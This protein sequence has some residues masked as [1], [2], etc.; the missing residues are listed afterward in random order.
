MAEE[1]GSG[2]RRTVACPDAWNSVAGVRGIEGGE[3]QTAAQVREDARAWIGIELG[4]SES[5][6]GV[7]NGGVRCGKAIGHG[8]VELGW[9]SGLGE[10]MEVTVVW[11]EE[12]QLP[13]F[14]GGLA[15]A[16]AGG[17]HLYGDGG[18]FGGG[19]TPPAHLPDPESEPYNIIPVHNLLADHPSLR[20]PEVRAAA[21]ALRAV[22]NLRR[23]PYAQWRSHMDILDWLALFFGFQYDNVRNQREHIVLHLANAQMRLTPPPDNIDTLDATVLRKF[24]KKLLLN[25]TNWCSYLGKKS[26]IWISDHRRDA[27]SDQ[28]RE[29]LYVCLYLLIWGEAANLRFVPECL[30]YIF[31]NMAME[32]NK[33]LEDYID[34]STGQP[35]M[36]SVSGE[37]AFLNCVVKPI[38][39]TIRAEVEGSKNGTAPHSVWRNYDD[40]NEYFWSKR[41]FDKLKWP[42][43]VG[44]TF[45]VTNTKGRHVGKTGFVE[46]RSFWNLFR[47]FDKLWIMLFMF[48]QAAIIVAWE[49]REYPW[50]ALENREV[51]VKVLTLFSLG[52]V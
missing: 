48:L 19:G 10:A 49:E 20:F 6:G 29:L 14:V 31:H 15:L 26:N 32:L 3:M 33:I 43:D 8:E 11:L 52:V 38:Y 23:P 22:G 27:A 45:F 13:R 16:M 40:I 25:Y 12:E 5:G 41:C 37:N 18:R 44:S 1:L 7:I 30:C 36:P 2:F 46:Q 28:R 34:E 24:R 9:L 51:Q 42:V 35:V 17:W 39:D 4:S 21:A 47:S 50:Q